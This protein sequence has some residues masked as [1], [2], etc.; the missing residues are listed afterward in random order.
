MEKNDVFKTLNAINV[1]E[2]VEIKDN[3]TVKLSYLSWAWA[4]AQAKQ[5][6]PDINFE[7]R[8]WDDKPYLYDEELGYMVETSVTIQ[9]ETLSMWLPVMDSNNKAMKSKPYTVKTKYKEITVKAATMFDIN[10]TIMRCLVKNIALFGLGLYIYAGED[11]PEEEVKK[12]RETSESDL[13]TAIAELDACK[14]TEDVSKVW[15]KWKKIH[16]EYVKQGH[17]FFVH[18]NSLDVEFA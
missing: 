18:S 17:K 8:H 15:E 6:Y 14:T 16:P 11:L 2:H 5:Q 10:T 9:G 3:G 12:A 1:N 4:W 13:P 7:V